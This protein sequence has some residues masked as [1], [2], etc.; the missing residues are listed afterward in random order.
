VPV[1]SAQP[2]NKKTFFNKKS[3]NKKNLTSINIYHIYIY[4]CTGVCVCVIRI[5]K[6]HLPEPIPI[7]VR[8][9]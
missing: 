9:S 6:I 7:Y 1:H 4:N 8:V 3:Y 5:Y 2:Y